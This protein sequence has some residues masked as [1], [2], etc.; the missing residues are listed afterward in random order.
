MKPVLL[1]LHGF[2]SSTGAA[3]AQPMGRQE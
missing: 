2:N 1:Y 3:K